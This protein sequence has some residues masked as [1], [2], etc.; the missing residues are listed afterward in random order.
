[1]LITTYRRPGVKVATPAHV[2]RIPDARL[3]PDLGVRLSLFAEFR[4]RAAVMARRPNHEAVPRNF[5]RDDLTG[6]IVGREPNRWPAAP[7]NAAMIQFIDGG[8]KSR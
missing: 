4:N 1:M 2:C 5:W 8:K 3:R 6:C 7:Q